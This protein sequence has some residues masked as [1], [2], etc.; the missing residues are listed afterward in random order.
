M[1]EGALLPVCYLV[2][3]KISRRPR[4]SE[5]FSVAPNNAI[6]GVTKVG[7]KIKGRDLRGGVRPGVRLL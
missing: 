1:G 3:G 7:E 4:P 2:F 5:S 6:D